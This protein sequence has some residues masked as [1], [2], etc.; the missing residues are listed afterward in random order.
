MARTL[1]HKLLAATTWKSCS[2]A[3][4]T[5]VTGYG[6]G[7]TVQ[8]DDGI[9]DIIQFT[10]P[11][12]PVITITGPGAQL[13]GDTGTVTHIFTVTSNIAVSADL[14]VNLTFNQGAT[15]AADY[16]G[17]VLPATSQTVTILAG[18]TTATKTAS[19]QA[20]T[21]YE[22][23]ETFTFTVAAGSGYTVGGT[24]T[25]TGTITN[26]DAG[27]PAFT[28]A[29]SISP[30]SGT[31]GT[32]TFTASD[33]T[34]SNATGS[35]RRWLLDGNP[36]G[37]GATIS[38]SSAQSGS[39]VLEVTATGPG[40]TTVATSSAVT[41]ASAVG[42][43]V[44]FEGDSITSPSY[45]YAMSNTWMAN[46]PAIASAN[47]SVPGAKIRSNS[48]NSL[49]ERRASVQ[50]AFSGVTNKILC[51]LIGANDLY[52]T[53]TYATV[54]DWQNSLLTLLTAYRADNPGVLI[55]VG[56][57][58]PV[59]ETL[60]SGRAG[61]NARR[62][63]VNAW[64][65]TQVGSTID[66]LIPYGDGHPVMGL[67]ATADTSAF[68]DG[69]HPSST[70]AGYMLATLNAALNPVV[71]GATGNLPTAF[72]FV[73]YTTAAA[74]TTYTLTTTVT[75][76]GMGQSVNA[77]VTGTGDVARGATPSGL[78]YS[79]GPIAVF[80]GDILTSRVTSSAT[81]GALLQHTLNVGARSDT[82]DVTTAPSTATTVWDQAFGIST[83]KYPSARE[84][85]GPLST[86]TGYNS[87]RPARGDK[88][89]PINSANKRYFEMTFTAG[90]TGSNGGPWQVAVIGST[91]GNTT[92]PGSGSGNG[93]GGVT[94][95]GD[96][97]GVYNNSATA[98][99][100]FPTFGSADVIGVAIDYNTN[101][102]WFLKNGVSISGD[103]VAGTGGFSMTVANS[104][105]WA[106]SAVLQRNEGHVLNCG[107]DPFSYTP[108]SGFVAYG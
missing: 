99:T 60:Q 71:A 55:G 11:A 65:R 69:L 74:S 28:V 81:N 89:Y 54:A 76:M 32:T 30:S 86:E 88:S 6:P 26:D 105:S 15:D 41:V 80:N 63:L 27:P 101:K 82:W 77:T 103:P 58:I 104:T 43:K 42:T 61:F 84:V 51:L 2:G 78:S 8:V 107:Q 100:G 68:N 50:S 97:G 35:T 24:S 12:L 1:K 91:T 75:G 37:T 36:I 79:T 73:D 59:S 7:D 62:V 4:G 53:G 17:G 92:R 47:L 40:G 25:A 31:A 85:K 18:S 72:T 90:V 108:P 106:P 38:P 83:L 10:I 64:M 96:T 23:N 22:S 48:G 13:E 3:P 39:L 16:A 56:T 57:I 19:T 95:R 52:L 98:T 102:V 44:V 33:G 49:D 94:Y 46:N 14:T 67:D 5:T 45:S 87:A 21:Q 93:F 70:G 20:D 66:F 9:S 34:I 29:P